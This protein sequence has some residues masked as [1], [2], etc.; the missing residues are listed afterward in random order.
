MLKITLNSLIILCFKNKMNVK[1]ILIYFFNEYKN[2][3]NNKQL[4]VYRYFIKLKDYFL[5]NLFYK[6]AFDFFRKT[7]KY[8]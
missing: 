1:I 8:M 7:Y 2:N 5:N 4:I 6:N 3:D